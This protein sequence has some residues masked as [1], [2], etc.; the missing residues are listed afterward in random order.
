MSYCCLESQSLV[1]LCAQQ[2]VQCLDNVTCTTKNSWLSV[3]THFHDWVMHISCT[4]SY[5]QA[6]STSYMNISHKATLRVAR[7]QD[8]KWMTFLWHTFSGWGS[9]RLDIAFAPKGGQYLIYGYLQPITTEVTQDLQ[10]KIVDG[11]LTLIFRIGKW[12]CH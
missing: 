7:A 1:V 12:P 4:V 11:K 8:Q 10:S 6:A 5:E 3:D 9:E 2:A